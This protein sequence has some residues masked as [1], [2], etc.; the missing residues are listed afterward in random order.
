MASSTHPSQ[1]GQQPHI[2]PD[3]ASLDGLTELCRHLEVQVLVGNLAELR[4]QEVVRRNVGRQV[5]VRQNVE[6][7]VDVR[8]NV[9]RQIDVRRMSECRASGGGPVE[10][11]ASGGGPA[12]RRALGG[13]PAEHRGSGGG[14]AERRG[15][16]GGPAERRASGGGPEEPRVSGGG[17]AAL[18]RQ[19]VV[20]WWSDRTPAMVEEEQGGKSDLRSLYLFL[21]AWVPFQEKWGLYL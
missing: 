5:Y 17:P 11:Q 7:Q 19:V 2:P 9:G 20:R 15:S 3:S 6:R 21:K 16:G 18:Q 1:A 4:R 13:D 12:E 14:P 8:Q 10:R